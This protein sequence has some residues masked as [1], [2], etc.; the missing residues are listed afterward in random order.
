MIY[1]PE[2]HLF[3]PNPWLLS[4]L[5]ILEKGRVAQGEARMVERG[6][7]EEHQASGIRE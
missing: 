5:I 1:K 6:R 7:I 2:I 3:S 4:A